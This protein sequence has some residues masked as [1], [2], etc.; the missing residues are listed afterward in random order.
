MH[1]LGRKKDLHIYAHHELKEIIDLQ[2]KASKTEFRF[3]LFF[4]A[5]PEEVGETVGQGVVV[6]PAGL[7]GKDHEL[8][9]TQQRTE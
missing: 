3:P 4:H 9:G 6:Q 1:L 2:M 8:W 5:L 7:A